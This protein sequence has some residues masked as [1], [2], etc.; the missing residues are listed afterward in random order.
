MK[1]QI[2][3]TSR[4]KKE[5]QLAK[6][7]GRDLTKLASLVNLLA[8]DVPLSKEHKDHPLKGDLADYR[9]CHIESDW[10]LIYKKDKGSLF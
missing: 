10:L 1:Y 9:E 8:Q 3:L 5:T 2:I 7:Q 4:F 6:K